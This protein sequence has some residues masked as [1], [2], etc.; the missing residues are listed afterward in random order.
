MEDID[1]LD[2][3]VPQMNKPVPGQCVCCASGDVETVRHVMLH[4]TAYNDIRSEWKEAMLRVARNA[5]DVCR[6]FRVDGFVRNTIL[7]VK[8]DSQEV[9]VRRSSRQI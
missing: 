7:K 9:V 1:S 6:E 5:S 2:E 3:V 8:E 4:C